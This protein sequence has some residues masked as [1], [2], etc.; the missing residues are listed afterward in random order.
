[1]RGL[2]IG[3]SAAADTLSPASRAYLE[4]I[5]CI[6]AFTVFLG[7]ADP[8]GCGH[9]RIRPWTGEK[10]PIGGSFIELETLFLCGAD[11]AVGGELSPASTLSTRRGLIYFA[12]FLAIVGAVT[13]A[14]L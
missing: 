12:D 11:P 2:L 9:R 5:P 1:M 8:V 3:E 13:G 10:L 7:A 6:P 4:F 14:V